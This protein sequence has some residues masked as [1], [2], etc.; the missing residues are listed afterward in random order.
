MRGAATAPDAD[1]SRQREIVDAFLSASRAGDFDA[2]VALLDPDVVLHADLGPTPTAVSPLVRG[3]AAVAGR[4]LMFARFATSTRH[5][6]VNGAAGPVSSQDGR[7][8]AVLGFTV[9]H[10]KIVAIDILADPERLD[11]LT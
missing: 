9:V 7:L 4:A 2:L 6:L 11:H 5:A 10:H 1:L 3:A 8:T